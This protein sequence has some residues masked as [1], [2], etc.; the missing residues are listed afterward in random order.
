LKISQW[1]IYNP[2]VVLWR[3][4]SEVGTYTRK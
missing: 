4:H 1:I 2:H 3:L